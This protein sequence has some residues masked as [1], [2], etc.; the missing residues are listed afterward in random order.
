MK[1]KT[2][3]VIKKKKKKRGKIANNIYFAEEGRK[4]KKGVIII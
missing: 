3:T 1:G 2:K 4:N